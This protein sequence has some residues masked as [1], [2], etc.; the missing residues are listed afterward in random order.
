M[1][2]ASSSIH[3]PC[4]N[5]C[6]IDHATKLC[7]GCGRTSVEIGGWLAMSPPERLAIMDALPA[8]LVIMA[9]PAREGSQTVTKKDLRS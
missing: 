8:R 9:D 6:V 1:S 7:M 2:I 3:S 5:V 4:N